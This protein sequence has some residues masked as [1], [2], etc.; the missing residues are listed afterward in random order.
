[1]PVFTRACLSDVRDIMAITRVPLVERLGQAVMGW[2]PA[3]K[4]LL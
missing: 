3:L 2:I 1:M 4:C